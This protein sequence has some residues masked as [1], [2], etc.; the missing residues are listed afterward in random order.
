M[1]G[2]MSSSPLDPP[3]SSGS[4][5]VLAGG[6]VAGIAWELGVLQGLADGDPALAE[7]VLSADLVVGTSAGST[8]AA[9]ITSG[10]T[11]DELYSAQ[12]RPT[13][14]ELEVD[15]DLPK[16]FAEFGAAIQGAA[17]PADNARRIAAIA[18]AASTVEPAV[19][20]AA[21]D[22]RL[23][24][25]QWPSRRVLVTAID[26]ESGELTV[27]TRDSA[28]SLTDAVAASSAVPGVWPPVAIGGRRYIDGG[29]RSMANADLAAGADRVLI[30]LPML[31]GAPQPW[32]SLDAEISA[33]TPASVHVIWA[34]QPSVEAF[35]A[36]P[37]SPATRGPSARAGRAVGAA[38]AAA[39][40]AFWK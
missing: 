13:T 7:R 15:L 18:L 40:A 29:V 14:T 3:T 11:L 27:F 38:H 20:R 34:D 8:V 30:I 22:A 36:N 2:T 6:G 19:R 24:I 26:T 12:L 28:V 32:G 5:L 1:M 4:A 37:L 31:E 10:V 16:L 23:P 25:K 21:I 35:G 17:G 9:Q 33:L 39:V